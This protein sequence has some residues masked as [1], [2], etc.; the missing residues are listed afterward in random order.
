[1][2]PFLCPIRPSVPQDSLAQNT[3]FSKKTHNKRKIDSRR[4][5]FI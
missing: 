1:M 2:T 3:F 5:G 4:R